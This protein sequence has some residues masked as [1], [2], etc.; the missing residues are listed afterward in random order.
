MRL[1]PAYPLFVKEPNFSIWQTSD[2]L[3]GANVSAWFG[4]EKSMYG[5]AKVDGETYCFLGD[6]AAWRKFGVKDAEQISLNVTSFTTD[7]VFK[8]GKSKLYL[9]FVSPLLPTDAEL[10]SMPVCYV[11]YRIEN[12]SDIEISLFVGQD[13]AYNK[14]KELCLDRTVR[15]AVFNCVDFQTAFLGLKRQMYLSNNEDLCGADWGYWYVAGEKAYA[16]ASE[17]MENYLSGNCAEFGNAGEF[18]YVAAVNRSLKGV[19]MLA[20]DDVV[21]IDYFGNFRKGLYLQKHGILDALRYVYSNSEKI[22]ARLGEFDA[23]LKRRADNVSNDY[24]GIA[25]ASL[26]QSIAAHKLISDEDGNLIFLSKECGSNG[27][28]ATVDVSYPSTPLYLLYNT[29]LVKGMMR[30]ILKVAR[31]PVWQFDFAPHDA[32]T[33]PYCCG[34]IYGL[35]GENKYSR[36]FK[37]KFGQLHAPYYN[38]TDDF[39]LYDSK[40][41]M[42]V[43]ECANMLIMFGACSHFD[44]DAKFFA[45]HFDLAQKWVKYLVECG[46]KPDNQLCTDD[47]AGHL[48]NNLNLAIKAV[49]GIACYA[50][51]CE[52]IGADGSQYM[53]TARK[54]ASEIEKFCAN[55]PY[56]PLTW[57][58]GDTYSL[59]YNLLFDKVLGFGLFSQ[60]FYRKETDCY[61]SKLNKFGVPLDS[62]KTYTKSDWLVWAA[63]LTDDADKRGLLL[64]S[65][66]VFLEESPARVPFSDWYDTLDG[67]QCAFQ[68]RSVQGGCFAPLLTVL[69]RKDV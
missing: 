58:G 6:C 17:D 32:G 18:K 39:C 54:Y 12:A 48:K 41:Q 60:E 26:R 53:Q 3:N 61:I 21:A 13:V 62:R 37:D 11:N 55:Y 2:T 42:P 20:Y 47:F 43:E 52:K 68:A 28:I 15:N 51:L 19:I 29:E 40:Y 9:S 31:M 59:K 63:A 36:V 4:E 46:L 44:G 66:K 57:D 27:C 67:S 1:L 49:V 69:S 65:V 56:S 30:P 22:D 24:Y 23:D 5:F 7:Y 8:L 33:Y 45:E 64:R 50:S 34:N 38:F 10:V 35:N 14:N 16:L 25:A